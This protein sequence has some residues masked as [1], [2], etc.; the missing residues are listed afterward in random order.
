MKIIIF[1]MALIPAL[2]MAQNYKCTIDDSSFIKLKI[3]DANSITAD[4]VND[5]KVVTSCLFSSQL[6][7]S[8]PRGAADTVIQNFTKA[9]C[10]KMEGKKVFKVSEK[11]Y[12]KISLDKKMATFF[13][14]SD[15]HPFDCILIK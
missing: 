15:Q 9:G 3:N 13:M 4:I 14:L 8:D 10:S 6:P 12:T 2:S 5:K 11:A 7:A 1:A